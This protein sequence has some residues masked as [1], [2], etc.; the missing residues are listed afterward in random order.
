MFH[1]ANSGAMP[2]DGD[3][4]TLVARIEAAVGSIPRKRFAVRAG[5]L[6]ACTERWPSHSA[7]RLCRDVC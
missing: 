5:R 6:R 2:K 3:W 7:P 1:G 4:D